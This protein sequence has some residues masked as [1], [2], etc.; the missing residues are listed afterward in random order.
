MQKLNRKSLIIW[1]I[2]GQDDQDLLKAHTLSVD[3]D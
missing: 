3:F 1:V 2:M